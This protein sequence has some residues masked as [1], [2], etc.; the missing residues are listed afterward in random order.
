MSTLTRRPLIA[1]VALITAA[2]AVP[3]D[4]QDTD[5][6]I[7]MQ[8]ALVVGR[9]GTGGRAPLHRDA[10]VA[11]IVAGT[12]RTPAAGDVITLPGGDTV[13]WTE[14]NA[15]GGRIRAPQRGG[16]ALWT[17]EVDEPRVMLLRARGHGVVYTNGRPRAGDP[18]NNGWARLPV[19]LRAGTNEFLFQVSRGPVQARLIEPPAD[20]FLLPSEATLANLVR[21]EDWAVHGGVL[22]VNATPEPVDGLVLR[23][24]GGP[25]PVRET[26]LPVVPP[27]SLRKVPFW[28]GGAVPPDLG[29]LP[30]KLELA[31]P[32]EGVMTVVHTAEPRIA[33]RD[34][35]ELHTRTFVSDIDGSV[36]YY[37]VMPMRRADADAGGDAPER[38]A[39]FLTLHGA[40]VEGRGQA[41]VYRPK[42]WGHVVAPTNRR[43]FGFDWEDWGR[44]D[45]LEVLALAEEHLGTDPDRTFLTGHSMGGH[46]TWH[47]GVT[48][49]G[50]WAAIGP[51]AGWR[52]FW[53]YSGAARY[54]NASPI[55]AMLMRSTNAS[56]TVRLSRNFLHHGIYVL[57]GDKDDNVPVEQA[58]FMKK[59]LADFHDDVAY[60][61][62]PGAGHWWG[63]QCCDWDPMFEF[64]RER[65]RPPRAEVDHIE[66]HTASP[67]VSA[68]SRWVGLEQQVEAMEFSSVVIDLDRAAR[69][70]DATTENVGRLVIDL[71][72][73]EPGSPVSVTVDAQALGA[74]TWPEE[75]AILSLV[76]DRGSARWSVAAETLAPDQKG[77]Q[78]YGPFKDAFRHRVVFVYATN[79][80]PAENEWSWAKARFDAET[81][82]YRGNAAV[83][84]IPDHAFDPKTYANRSVIVYGHA[85]ANGAWPVLLAD[86]PVQVRRGGVTVGERRFDGDDLGCLFVR[87]R[88]DSDVASVGVVAGTG[89]AGLRLTDR[90]RTFVSG[91]GYPDCLVIGPEVLREAPPAGVRAAGFFGMDWGVESGTFAWSTP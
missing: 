8:R 11:Q 91:I 51:S 85:D 21:G 59:L 83:E 41:A 57:H 54:E 86:S 35:D 58:R 47:L 12:W 90:L 4:A 66:F 40:S 39:L 64:F 6:P 81:F 31:R 30:L 49:P 20:V 50:K 89:L 63:S 76:R 88:P 71:D 67:G 9:V 60:H 7:V 62:Q 44:L 3:A 25:L 46:G 55:E 17:V 42:T 69:A 72:H 84:M 79:G 53:S 75:D 73:L 10:I 22:V 68:W 82:W 37:A 87:P 19:Q 52:S 70:F 61:E 18:Y 80:T 27:L 56:D 16:Y 15:E 23:A 32:V 28:Y 48:F 78:R 26:T 34:A 13:T 74:V 77:P 38:P 1:L 2:T 36:Q 33:A 45:A 43:P 14:A 65:S 29:R 5:D 24:G